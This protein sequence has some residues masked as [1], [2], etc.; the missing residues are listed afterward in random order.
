M[1]EII[2]YDELPR[3][4]PLYAL[5][6]EDALIVRDDKENTIFLSNV[7]NPDL[8]ITELAYAHG[9]EPHYAT[10]HEVIDLR[11]GDLIRKVMENAGLRVNVIESA[12]PR[13]TDKGVYALV[14]RGQ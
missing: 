13:M 1:I 5:G 14:K 9:M 2:H 6:E 3:R 10:S 12:F 8:A 7:D 11:E 4:K